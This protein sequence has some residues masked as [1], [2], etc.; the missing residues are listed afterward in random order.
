MTEE[1]SLIHRCKRC[2]E[3][4]IGFN[5]EVEPDAVGLP[6]EQT[7]VLCED[8]GKEYKEWKRSQIVH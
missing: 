3:L 1:E 4:F 8:C 6:K 5:E 7:T 2:G